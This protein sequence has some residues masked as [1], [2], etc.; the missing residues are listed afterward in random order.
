M[1]KKKSIEE[2]YRLFRQR[3][4]DSDLPFYHR[5]N[6]LKKLDR[7]KYELFGVEENDA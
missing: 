7:V 5:L 3:I 2:K 4:I 1:K 6:Q